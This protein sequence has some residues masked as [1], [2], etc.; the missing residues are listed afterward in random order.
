MCFSHKSALVFAL[1]VV[2][3]GTFSVKRAESAG[4]GKVDALSEER[5]LLTIVRVGSYQDG[6]SALN[7]LVN[8]DARE[9]LTTRGF[10]YQKH[11]DFEHALADYNEAVKN[12]PELA[13]SYRGNF[14]RATGRFEEALADYDRLIEL[15]K[16]KVEIENDRS[17]TTRKAHH[18]LA[19]SYLG[20]AQVYADQKCIPQAV[21]DLSRA[22]ETSDLY[23][24]EYADFAE[25]Y[26]SKA[27]YLD[28][29]NKLVS[30]WPNDYLLRRAILF[31][32]Q[33]ELEKALGDYDL[34]VETFE[35][36][37]IK[38]GYSPKAWAL[39]AREGYYRRHNNL[40]LAERDNKLA[41][42]YERKQRLLYG[43]SAWPNR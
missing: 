15:L 16:S 13:L 10:F 30:K 17:V 31:E 41:L 7:R 5:R 14:Y 40:E 18:L 2:L 38:D 34:A 8:N 33:D 42:K 20:R 11:G 9:F 22:T 4:D 3:S 26:G 35:R 36:Y 32:S 12:W 6:L 1:L 23:R 19:K 39:K 43:F 29:L 27:D 37:G 28:I 21:T 25:K 24:V